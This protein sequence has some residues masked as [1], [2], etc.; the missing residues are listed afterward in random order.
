MA[1]KWIPFLFFLLVAFLELMDVTG[2]VLT[3]ITSSLLQSTAEQLGISVQA[4]QLR[5]FALIPITG[6]M[7][8]VFNMVAW[9][10]R[11]N[12]V[13]FTSPWH[14]RYTWAAIISAI[15]GAFHTISY[16]TLQ[17]PNPFIWIA[18][19][20]FAIAVLSLRMGNWVVS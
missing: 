17:Q 9:A 2:N 16:F 1:K 19:I 18:V 14:G 3:L 11:P 6:A 20:Y 8:F 5:L 7:F 12:Q 10:L 13:S 4:E 15:Y